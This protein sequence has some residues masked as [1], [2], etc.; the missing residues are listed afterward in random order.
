MCVSVFLYMCVRIIVRVYASVCVCVCILVR[1]CSSV[2]D[3]RVVTV[4]IVGPG[5]RAATAADCW[6]GR[7]RRRREG[8]KES[9]SRFC[10]GSTTPGPG[11]PA[12]PARVIMFSYVRA[13]VTR[14]PL[15]P[16]AKNAREKLPTR[17]D[18]G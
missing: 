8:T 16:Y 11:R 12:T 9:G 1:V 4:V 17:S 5:G 18:H 10:A 7:A 14:T 2:C 3:V 15:S 13:R 6:T